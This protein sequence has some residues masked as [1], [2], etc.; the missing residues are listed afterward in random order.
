MSNWELNPLRKSQ[1]HYASL[2]AYI[3]IPVLKQLIVIGQ[4]KQIPLSKCI[5]N[6]DHRDFNFEVVEEVKED[7]NSH[8]GKSH[9]Q[10]K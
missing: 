2:D 6:M 8:Y 3:L 9:M 1:M 5:H 7:F 4:E 10:R